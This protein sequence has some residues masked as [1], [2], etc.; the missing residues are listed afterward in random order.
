MAMN[1]QIEKTERTSVSQDSWLGM[2]IISVP[3]KLFH[4]QSGSYLLSW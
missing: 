4:W 1:I 3:H 2:S